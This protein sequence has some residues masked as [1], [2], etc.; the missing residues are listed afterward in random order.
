MMEPAYHLFEDHSSG[1]LAISCVT[2]QISDGGDTDAIELSWTGKDEMDDAQEVGGGDPA[3]R[4]SQRSN[5]LPRRRGS[6]FI[7]RREASSTACC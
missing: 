5:L 2:G 6:N 7:A 4:L 3:R 1:E